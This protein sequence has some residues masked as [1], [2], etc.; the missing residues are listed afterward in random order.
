MTGVVHRTQYAL[1]ECYYMTD[2]LFM[3]SII[4]VYSNSDKARGNLREMDL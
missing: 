1:N 4:H 2:I 3:L